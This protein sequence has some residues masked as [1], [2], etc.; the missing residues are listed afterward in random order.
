MYNRGVYI[1]R[2]EG[3]HLLRRG[4]TSIAKGCTPI[5]KGCTPI[6]KGCTTNASLYEYPFFM[7]GGGLV[8][9]NF[10]IFFFFAVDCGGEARLY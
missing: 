4:C 3:V 9:D 2:R 5:A 10:I 1:Y 8:K 6:A 7:T